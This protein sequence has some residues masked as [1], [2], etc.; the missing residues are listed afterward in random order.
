MSE[1]IKKF[2]TLT[3]LSA[4]PGQESSVR[5]FIKKNIEKIVDK[6]EY[7]N[8]GSLNAFKGLNG[9][10]IMLASHMDEI[11]ARNDA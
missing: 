1:L 8:L 9:P 11:G 3:M 7:D 10:K 5:N 6:I 4:V 2:K